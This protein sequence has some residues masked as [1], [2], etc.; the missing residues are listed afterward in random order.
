M[1]ILVTG[2]NGFTGQHLSVFLAEQG[3]SV[4]AVSRGPSRLQPHSNIQ[5]YECELTNVSSVL[6]VVEV[7]Q[8]D[9]IIHVAAMSKPD[10]CD[11]NREKCLKQ[12]VD[13]T[14]H[15]GAAAQKVNARFVYFSTDFIF[16]ENGPHKEEDI[17]NP[18]NFYGESKWKAEQW[19]SSQITNPVI[20]RPVFMYG[21]QH[22][23]GRASFIQW[24]EKQLSQGKP[25]KVVND[26]YRTPTYIKDICL[27]VQSIMV[28]NQTGIFHLAGPQIITPYDMAIE[29]AKVLSLNQSLIT[30]V[31]SNTFPEPVIRAKRSGL[32]IDKAR[33]VLN[34]KPH[35]F[36]EGV[37]LSFA[38]K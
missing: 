33:K 11:V 19:V 21:P 32:Q 13:A 36:S 16:G 18:L 22:K 17:P 8:P 29:V 10:E 4:H 38:A 20:V 9:W 23:N 12:N 24:V 1:N 2:A 26:Q 5:Y 28:Q 7:I 34:Y 27:G 30:P 3:F 25:I 14:I 35:S 31:D 37:H 6:K 15:L